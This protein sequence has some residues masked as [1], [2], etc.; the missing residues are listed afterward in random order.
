MGGE[1]VRPEVREA[2]ERYL[3]AWGGWRGGGGAPEGQAEVA[4]LYRE[5]LTVARAEVPEVLWNLW[6]GPPPAQRSLLDGP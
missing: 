2:Y 3:V 5:W 4:R 6:D 1:V